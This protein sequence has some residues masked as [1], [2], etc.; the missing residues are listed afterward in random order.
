MR[1]SSFFGDLCSASRMAASM[2][3]VK[4]ETEGA[5]VAAGDR[6]AMMAI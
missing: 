5:L 1:A 4:K 6:F 2:R 3:A